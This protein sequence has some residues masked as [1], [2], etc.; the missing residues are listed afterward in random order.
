MCT[1]A[2]ISDVVDDTIDPTLINRRCV[3]KGEVT[4]QTDENIALVNFYTI[5]NVNNVVSHRI[6]HSPVDEY[7]FAQINL[8]TYLSTLLI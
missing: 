4:G 1:V 5:S 6:S 7:I 2:E 8:T 3:D